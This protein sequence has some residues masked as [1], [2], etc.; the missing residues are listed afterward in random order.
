MI[1]T[2]YEDNP[3]PKQI[4]QIVRVLEQGGVIIYPTDTLY[5]FAC[6]INNAKAARRLAALKGKMLEKSYFSIVCRNISQVSQYVKPLSNE[7]FRILK[8]NLPGSFTFVLKTS[9]LTPRIFQTKRQTI[10][11]RVP[12]NAIALAIVE[13]FGRPVLT[14]SLCRDGKCTEDYADAGL[15]E[16]QYGNK[17][18]LIVDGGQISNIPSTVVSLIDDQTAILREGLC[19][20]RL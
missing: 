8:A 13:M 15:I 10:G 11:I 6:D 16:E 18:D 14:S 2:L 4:E 12:N 3:N 5:A 19:L 1:L 7:Q 9:P 17:V 20:P